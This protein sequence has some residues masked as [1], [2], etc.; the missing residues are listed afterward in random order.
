[1][2]KQEEHKEKTRT[3]HENTMKSQGGKVET[4]REKGKRTTQGKHFDNTKKNNDN[5]TRER[6]DDIET[7]GEKQDKQR[8]HKEQTMRNT[9]NL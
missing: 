2:S 9:D 1:L 3:S 8:Q 4:T 7:Q 5:T 6:E